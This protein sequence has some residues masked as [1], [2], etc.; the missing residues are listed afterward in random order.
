MGIKKVRLNS[1]RIFSEEFKK[2]RVKEYEK[3]EYSV[4][5]LGKLFDIQQAV[6]YRWIYKYSIY[7]RKSYKIVEMKESSTK[8]VKDL[9]ERIKVLERVVGQKQLNIDYLEKLIEIADRE[10]NIEIKKKSDTSQLAGLKKI[11]GI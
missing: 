11:E 6:I 5:E 8:K 7:N 3:G 9:E 2:S 10:F 1:R 4:T